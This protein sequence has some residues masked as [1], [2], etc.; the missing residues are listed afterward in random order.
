[1]GLGIYVR[2]TCLCLYSRPPRTPPGV[3]FEPER[4]R[5]F[6]RGLEREL[7]LWCSKGSYFSVKVVVRTPG[8]L[9]ANINLGFMVVL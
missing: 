1:M 5:S 4:F 7:Y 6:H 8:S 3:E 2:V 9:R